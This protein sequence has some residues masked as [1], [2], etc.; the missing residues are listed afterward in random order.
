LS[1]LISNTLKA[2]K[3][4]LARRVKVFRW[5]PATDEKNSYHPR[6]GKIEVKNRSEKI[7]V[8]K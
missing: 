4:A 8:K 2:V 7:D 5:L 1:N 6:T 3:R